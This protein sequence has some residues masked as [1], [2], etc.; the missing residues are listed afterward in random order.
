[1]IPNY[2]RIDIIKIHKDIDNE[3]ENRFPKVISLLIILTMDKSQLNQF[4]S[5]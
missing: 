5:S 4:K 1:M 3:N 2:K